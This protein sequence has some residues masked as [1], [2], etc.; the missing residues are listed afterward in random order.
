MR[1]VLTADLDT[2]A[3]A[4]AAVPPAERPALIAA[5]L[6]AAHCADK[7]RKRTGRA[8]PRWG[9]GTLAA[10]A[11]RAPLAPPPRRYDAAA[12]AALAAVLA[13]LAHWRADPA[14]RPLKLVR[15]PYLR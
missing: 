5:L 7:W 4:L 8:H 1:A 15:G 9:D 12:T 3:R 14:R 6:T 13:G 10:A 11:A 2:A